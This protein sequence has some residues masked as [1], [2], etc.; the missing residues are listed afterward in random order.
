M[1]DWVAEVQ[2]KLDEQINSA[3]LPILESIESIRSMPRT[4]CLVYMTEQHDGGQA[5]YCE[6]YKDEKVARAA[7]EKDGFVQTPNRHSDCLIRKDEFSSYPDTAT[8]VPE[9]KVKTD[10]A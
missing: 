5:S 7:L 6:V 9:V 4:V 1:D 2:K 10:D 3:Y 8:I